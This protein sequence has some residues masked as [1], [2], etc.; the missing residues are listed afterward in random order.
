MDAY[1]L[2]IKY[3]GNNKQTRMLKILKYISQKYTTLIKLK[4]INSY[5][6]TKW[7]IMWRHSTVD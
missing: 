4:D 6:L 5:N 1:C 2:P 3:D 7:D